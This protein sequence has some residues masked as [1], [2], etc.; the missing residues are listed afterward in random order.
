MDNEFLPLPAELVRVEALTADKKLYRV[1][2][3]DDRIQKKFFFKPGQ[4]VEISVA[5]IGEMPIS[6]AS[7]P[8]A[9]EYF[10]L[11]I[12]R[13]GRVTKAIHSMKEGDMVGIR[14]PYGNGFSLENFYGYNMLFIAGGIGLPPLKSLI[15]TIL[16]ER[17]KFGSL[18]IFYGARDPDDLIFVDD[19]MEW[20]RY[21]T[22][23][24][25]VDK[26]N[27]EWNGQVGFVSDLV[28]MAEI[29]R[30]SYAV[31]CGP[32]AMFGPVAEKLREKGIDEVKIT[33]SA[34]RRM[35]CGIGK[36][37]HCIAGERY[38]CTDGPVF[39]YEEYRKL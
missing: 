5:G 23:E 15:E 3:K 4:F 22:V 20:K 38:I 28:G 21:A 10:E 25:T 2:F 39:T 18:Q 17:E 6:I 9:K 32:H 31:M 37:G 7:P 11:C 34:E 27:E 24:I 8:S 29:E 14:G 35:K 26:G 30:N 13:S 19:L 36:C 33:V 16:A 12:K 1:R